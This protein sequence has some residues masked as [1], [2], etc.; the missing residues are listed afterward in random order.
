MRSN[1]PILQQCYIYT[2]RPPTYY[3][4]NIVGC[5]GGDE[6]DDAII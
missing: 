4:S 5:Y 6:L 2:I 3:S 1:P